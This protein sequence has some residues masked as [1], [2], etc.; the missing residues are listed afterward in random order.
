MARNVD[1]KESFAV[2]NTTKGKAP[3]L[4]FERIKNAVLG[5]SY[6]L[7]LVFVGDAVSKKLNYI[8]RQKN[9]PTNILSFPLSK[10][11]GEIFINLKLAR[12]EA[13]KIGKKYANYVGFLFIHG[14]LHLK[15]YDHGKT[16]E[17][18]EEKYLKRFT[19]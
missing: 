6:D 15:G 1:K 4:P 11:E 8:Y 12:A 2:K 13:N 3:V 14:L 18:L 17:G 10:K 7:S 9:K 19:L 16:I 5:K